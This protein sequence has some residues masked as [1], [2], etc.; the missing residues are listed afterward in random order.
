MAKRFRFRLDTVLKVRKQRED[1]CRRAV[2]DRLRQIAAVQAEIGSLQHQIGE[3][4]GAFRQVHSVGRLDMTQIVRQRHWLIHL[5]Q[6]VLMAQASLGDLHKKL[7]EDRRV[8][9][10]ARKQT[11]V[12]E[13]LKERQI[14]RHQKETARAEAI[15]NDEIGNVLYAR[16]MVAVTE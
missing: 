9:V 12:L 4:I 16:Q 7:E 1:V 3:E 10:E 2:A 6:G 8:L 14:E 13:K 15:E 11:R 5:H